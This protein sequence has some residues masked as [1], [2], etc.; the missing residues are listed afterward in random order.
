MVLASA[1]NRQ[2]WTEDVQEWICGVHDARGTDT[3]CGGLRSLAATSSSLTPHRSLMLGYS[4]PCSAG[5][6]ILPKAIPSVPDLRHL[7][8]TI[9]SDGCFRQRR[10]SSCSNCLNRGNML[11]IPARS[12]ER[13]RLAVGHERLRVPSKQV[14]CCMA[15]AAGEG[16]SRPEPDSACDPARAGGYGDDGRPLLAQVRWAQARASRR[17][18]DLLWSHLVD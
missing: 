14:G 16:G 7:S 11:Q 9:S 18:A 2:N 17:A 10:P 4:P 5:R 12:Q 15:G 6:H 1:P 3:Q 8:L 13:C